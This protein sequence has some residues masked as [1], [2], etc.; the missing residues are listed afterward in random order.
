MIVIPLPIQDPIPLPRQIEV[1]AVAGWLHE[2][3]NVERTHDDYHD[4]IRK[5]I[6]RLQGV[7]LNLDSSTQAVADVLQ[8]WLAESTNPNRTTPL[9]HATMNKRRAAIAS[10]YEY[11][12]R[13]GYVTETP[14]RHLRKGEKVHSYANA[15]PIPSVEVKARMAAIDRST[16]MGK[17]DHALLSIAFT[18]GRRLAELAGMR[19]EDIAISGESITITFRTKGGKTIRDTL[20]T[21]VANALMTYMHSAFGDDLALPPNQAIWLSYSSQN[22]RKPLGKAGIAD[23]CER[24]LGT[25]KVHTLRHTFSKAMLDSGATVVELA[26]RLGHDNIATTNTYVRQLQS[27]E[28]PYAQK[29]VELFGIGE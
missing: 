19:W 10:F 2:H 1:H 22:Y 7:G 17:R 5:F 29:L 28:N 3:S 20:W 23:I 13:R 27:A 12:V 8:V 11:A 4:L 21:Q 24:Y 16:H 25:S 15:V 18:T 26:D 6:Q 9:A 14:I